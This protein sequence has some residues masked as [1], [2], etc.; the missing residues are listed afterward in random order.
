MPTMPLPNVTTADQLLVLHDPGWR[1]ELWRGELRRMSPAGHW[2]SSL[3]L[4]LG[5][6]LEVHARRHRLGRVYGA[7]GGFLLAHDPDTVLAPDVAFVQRD[8][9][10]PKGHH[11]FFPGPP[12]LAVEVISPDELSSHVASKVAAWL[13]HGSQEVWVVDLQRCTLAVHRDGAATRILRQGDR[14]RDS[15]VLPGF[16]LELAELFDD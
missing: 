14:L 4:R 2:H 8:R 5:A 11:G 1:H 6:M 3:A 7:D 16:T 15:I 12:D 10:P 9:L 13:S